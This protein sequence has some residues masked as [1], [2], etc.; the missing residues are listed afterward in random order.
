MCTLRAKKDYKIACKSPDLN[1]EGLSMLGVIGGMGPLATADFFAKLLAATP[2]TGDAGHVPVLILSDPRIPPRSPAILGDGE[3]P[4]PALRATRDKLVSAGA[5]FLAMP[6]NT[7]HFWHAELAAD[8]PVPFLSIIDATCDEIAARAAPGDAVGIIATRATLATHLYDSRLA[9]RGYLPRMPDDLALHN[10]I[11]PA[12]D[13]VKAGKTTEGGRLLLPAIE[14]FI[15]RGARAVV[16]ACTE[17]PMALDAV[18]SPL[19]CY[20]IDSTAALARACVA[21]WR[22]RHA[23][24]NRAG[25]GLPP[26]ATFP[27]RTGRLTRKMIPALH[28][29]THPS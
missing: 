28:A 18:D 22:E 13:L 4:L 7:A 21:S 16:L 12:I 2:A 11:L 8:C 20:C 27:K 17:T 9:A 15:A 23:R 10:I 3:S 6:C 25:G 29:K 5:T 24:R 14:Q 19:R 26:E 1:I